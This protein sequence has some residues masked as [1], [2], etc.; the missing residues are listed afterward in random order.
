MCRSAF[1]VTPVIDEFTEVDD[2]V[3]GCPKNW[4]LPHWDCFRCSGYSSP[5]SMYSSIRGC[6]RRCWLLFLFRRAVSV[7]GWMTA[8]ISRYWSRRE[9]IVADARGVHRVRP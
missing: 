6:S 3:F 8:G 2:S 4:L 5:T 9:D 1:P 7:L